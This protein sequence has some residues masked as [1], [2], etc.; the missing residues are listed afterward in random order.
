VSSLDFKV[1]SAELGN[2]VASV[3]VGGEVDL[4]TAPEL[5]EVL[6]GVIDGGARFVLVDLSTATFIDSTTLGV[7]MGAVKRV[8][9]DGGEIA[10][11]CKDPNIRKIFEITLLDRVFAIFDTPDEGAQ[12]LRRGASEGG[13]RA[14]TSVA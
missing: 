6:N 5:K 2:G 12:H 8:R 10:I 7:L 11:A 14:A 3:V 1:S 9:P 13:H 4:S